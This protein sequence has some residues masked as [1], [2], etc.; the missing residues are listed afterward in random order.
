MSALNLDLNYFDH[1]K[2]I[3]LVCLLGKGAEVLPLRMWCF[4]G[5]MHPEN[6]SLTAYSTKE[7]ESILRWWG[8][9][10]EAV[11]ALQKVKLLDKREDGYY[12]HDWSE[13]AGHLEAFKIRAQKAN[14]ARWAKIKG[15]SYK[16]PTS[17]HDGGDKDSSY[18]SNQSHS[19]QEKGNGVASERKKSSFL[20]KVEAIK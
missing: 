8:G 5:R 16:H 15:E 19:S 14:K 11:R 20:R 12:V 17:I 10:G 18:L 7:I 6:G 13:H 2:V 9:K 4:V 1:P 3:A